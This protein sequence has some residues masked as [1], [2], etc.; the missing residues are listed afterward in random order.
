MAASIT[1]LTLWLNV[2]SN[3][4]DYRSFPLMSSLDLELT[5]SGEFREYA[6]GNTRMILRDKRGNVFDVTLPQ[7]ERT[8]VDWLKTNTGKVVCVRDDRGNKTWAGYLTTS[9]KIN[10]G[11]TTSDVSLKLTEVTYSEVV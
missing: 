6:N 11:E 10:Q 8:D 4:S 5:Q 1:I 2:A 7:L 9:V 3:P